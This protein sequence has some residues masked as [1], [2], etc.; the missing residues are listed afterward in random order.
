MNKTKRLLSFIQLNSPHLVL[1]NVRK[2]RQFL[3]RSKS[4]Q[5]YI[6][7]ELMGVRSQT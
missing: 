2:H 1:D 6:A 7:Y 3:L 5:Q 4:L